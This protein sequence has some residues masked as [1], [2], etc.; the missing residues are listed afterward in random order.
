MR[1]VAKR[2]V[3]GGFALAEVEARFFGDLQFPRL[4]TGSLMGAIAERAVACS[5][6]ATPPVGSRFQFNPDRLG[7][8]AYGFFRHGRFSGFPL[9]GKMR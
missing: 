5:T 7:V 6:A 4:Q 8:T 3:S 1:S 2:G 9:L